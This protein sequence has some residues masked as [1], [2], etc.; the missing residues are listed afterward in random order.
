M[1]GVVSALSAS[2]GMCTDKTMVM[3][4]AILVRKAY[5]QENLLSHN[6]DNTFIL[7]EVVIMD[8]EVG[9][10]RSM[11]TPFTPPHDGASATFCGMNPQT[12]R[13]PHSSQPAYILD[14]WFM[15]L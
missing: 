9:D 10:G 11:S 7:M 5:R 8:L 3:K 6:H 1:N 4:L 2:S 13:Q 12:P 15:Q 14:S